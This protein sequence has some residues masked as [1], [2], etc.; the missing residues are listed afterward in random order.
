MENKHII[1]TYK[2]YPITLEYGK[3]A[4]VYDKNGKEYL[5]FA[6]GIAVSSLGYG[7]IDFADTLKG[8][9]DKLIHTSNLYY[10]ETCGRA[11]ADLARISKMEQVFFC[12]SGTEATE[13]AL[14]VARKYAHLKGNGR[15][16][17]IT[18]QDSFHGR[19]MGAL[20]V[21]GREQY[22][23]PFEPLIPKVHFAKYNDLESVQQL[24]SDKVCA[25]ILEPLQGEGGIHLAD[26]AF[27]KGVR[28]ICDENDIL[29]IF[30]EIQCGMGRTGSMFLWQ[31]IGVKPDVMTMAKAIGN[32]VPV[33]AFAINEK[34]AQYS[35]KPGDHGTTYGGNPLACAAVSKTIEI[36]EKEHLVDNAKEVGA[37][38]SEKLDAIVAEFDCVKERRG[39]GLIQGIAINIPSEHII[40]RALDEGLLVISAGVNVIRMVPPLIITKEQVDEAMAKLIRAL[41]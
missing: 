8:Q 12:N 5:D 3:G 16:E 15:S 19:S 18:M 20:S 10:N 36:F 35:L 32:G 26:E 29:L 27:L 30:D 25:I 17:F 24:I 9:I 2:R 33:G 21:T 39:T 34:V 6:A 23:I 28:K 31:R 4:Y 1:D 14:K 13:G 7:N 40:K 22:R 38:L 37:Y 11:A 41:N